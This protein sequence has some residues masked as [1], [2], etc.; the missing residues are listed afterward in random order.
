MSEPL[1]RCH[2]VFGLGDFSRLLSH[3]AVA[4][5]ALIL[6]VALKNLL[7]VPIEKDLEFVVTRS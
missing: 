5:I 1:E 7:H 4:Q 3:I 2:L 6:L